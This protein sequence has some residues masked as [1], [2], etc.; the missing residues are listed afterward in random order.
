MKNPALSYRQMSVRGASPLGLVVMLYDGAIAALRKAVVATEARDISEKCTHLAHAQAIVLQLEGSLN[1]A[2]GGD[3]AQT[4]KALYVYV[5]GQILKANLENSPE[6]LQALVEKMIPIREAWYTADHRP[7]DEAM[8]GQL[9]ALVPA[10]AT[11]GN[12]TLPPSQVR[13]NPL[14]ASIPQVESPSR[15]FAG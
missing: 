6:I 4:L 8:G 3:V 5:R 13:E 9:P 15:K 12:A 1:F 7:P 2:Q 11:E 10:A 14:Y